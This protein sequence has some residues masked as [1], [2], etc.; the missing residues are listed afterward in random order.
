MPRS[1]LF[2]ILP[3]DRPAA[4]LAPLIPDLLRTG[5]VAC[6]AL[7]RESDEEAEWQRAI[8]LLREPVQA[9]DVPFLL[10]DRADLAGRT[11]CDGAMVAAETGDPLGPLGEAGLKPVDMKAARAAVGA[12]AILGARCDG[13][14]HAAMVTAETGA[15]F[16][17]LTADEDLISWW[18]EVFEVPS[19]ALG[20][21]GLVPADAA[22]LAE[23]GADFIALDPESLWRGP[24]NEG[25]LDRLAKI[26]AAVAPIGAD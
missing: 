16:V 18:A 2:L 19:V 3:P 15:D 6:V 26:E 1:R 21:P 12:D 17:A 10:I 25:V 8:D 7:A 5:D 22:R 9:A 14:R 11:G 23:A 24:G 20:G 13:S 4:E